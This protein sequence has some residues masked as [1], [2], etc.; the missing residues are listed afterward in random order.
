MKEFMLLLA[1]LAVQTTVN[2]DQGY[3]AY[4]NL[5]NQQMYDKLLFSED[6][7]LSWLYNDGKG[8]TISTVYSAY[9]WNDTLNGTFSNFGIEVGYMEYF[10]KQ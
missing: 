5:K 7:T 8:S 9:N 10:Y 6:M 1:M 3:T 4:L 2:A